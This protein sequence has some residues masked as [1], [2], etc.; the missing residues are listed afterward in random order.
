MKRKA[1]VIETVQTSTDTITEESLV[2]LPVEGKYETMEGPCKVEVMAMGGASFDYQS[3][4][5]SASVTI[6]GVDLG[7]LPE[8]QAM[9]ED[10]AFDRV[11]GMEPR[12]QELLDILLQSK[13]TR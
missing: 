3:V 5:F 12:A 11:V 9:A 10:L 4:K 2:D 6:E 7:E 8:S 1:K 13:S